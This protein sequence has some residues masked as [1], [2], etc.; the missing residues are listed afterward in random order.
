[1][2]SPKRLPGAYVPGEVENSVYKFWEK[3]RI[4]A[5]VKEWRKGRPLFN[6]LDGPPYP[7]GDMPHAGTAWNKVIKDAVLRFYRMRGYNVND[8]PGYDCH[9]L[10]IEVAVE[11]K[12]GIKVKKEIEEK[13][14]VDSFIDKCK[15]FA[16]NNINGLTKWFKRLGV[17]MDWDNPY[18]TLNDEYIEAA[19]W[20]IKK[21]NAQGLLDRDYRVVYWCPR[22]ETTLA[23]YEVEYTVLRDPSIY[24][25]F[26]LR[27]ER[28]TYI[29]VWTTTPWTLPANTFVMA[30]PEALYVKVKVGNEYYI[31][32]MTRLEK[33]MEE[34]G[35]TEYEVVERIQGKALEGKEYVNPLEELVPLQKRL[36]KYHRI[37]MAPKYV[38]LHEG[39]GF[40]HAAPGHGFEDFEVAKE[41]GVDEIISPITDDGR[42]TED[43]GK[44]AGLPAREANEEIIKDLERIGAL[45][46]RASIEHRYPICWRC[47]T[48]VLL[49]ATTQ[50]IL[51]VTRLRD[52]L[53]EEAR[54]ANWIPRWALN[55]LNAML[56]NLQ[57][58]VLSRQRYWGIP[59][60]IWICEKCGHIV[61]AGSID[62]LKRYGGS[63][64]R[65]LHK[66]WIDQVTL[67]CPKCGGVMR[68]VP[69]VVDV[70]FDSGVAFY[71]S[72]GHP[73]KSSLLLSEKRYKADFIVEGHDQT[74][75][76]FFSLL[77]A[78]VIGFNEVPYRN[79][80]VHGFM[81]DRYGRE[82]HK[83]LGNYVAISEIVEKEGADVFRFWVLQNTTWEDARFSWE[84]LEE[85]RSDLNIAWNVF[86]FAST[87][88]ELDRFD[89]GRYGLDEYWEKLRPE[90]KWLLSR[91]AK[92]VENVTKAFTEYRVHDA[93]KLL[94]DYIIGD[95][96]HWYIRLIRKRVWVEGESEDKNAAYITLYT[97]L[98]T[99]LLLAAPIIPFFTEKIYQYFVREAEPRA[100]ISVHL[101]D[102]PLVRSNWINEELE[103]EMSLV[104]DL[105][106]AVAALRMKAG[107]KLRQPLRQVIVFTDKSDVHMAL[108][109]L[110]DLALQVVN[111]KH[112]EVRT[113]GEKE[114]F[115]EYHVEPV[116]QV[117]GPEFRRKARDIVNYI[118][119]KGSEIARDIL[120]KGEHVFTIDGEEIRLTNRHVKI[121]PVYK[122]G[123]Y[124]LPRDWGTVLIDTTLSEKEISEGFARDLVRRIQ[125]MR[126]EMGL[127]IEDKITVYLDVPDDYQKYVTENYDYIAGEVRATRIKIVDRDTLEKLSDY[128]RSWDIGGVRVIIGIKREG[129]DG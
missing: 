125:Y 71:A 69:D 21:A 58:W 39:T 34:A 90:D 10:P 53:V 54:K 22:C 52:K 86:V 96:S 82:M 84:K 121:I 106:E 94:K 113:L 118:R 68:R 78:G 73:E 11:K 38:S 56:D 93:V 126:K 47:K 2:A 108:N 32:A 65:E 30:H 42:F 76:W 40:V 36:S 87:Y 55:R 17:F 7:S 79:V 120:E 101:N 112:L 44:Y 111:A 9:G 23:E 5:K 127:D 60:P 18:L 50:W 114:A 28:N 57:D 105:A 1:M 117:I 110:R 24:V 12:L 103:N 41:I 27:G 115:V 91:T 51:R 3:E 19:W 61:V 15:E 37:V 89:P 123:Y 8:R 35:I 97:A 48:P 13:I 63:V 122:T 49:R 107:I 75:G 26:P 85:A 62:D 124:A 92:L 43:A 20:L 25:K 14:G 45:F 88:M 6:F 81:L 59:L 4:Y 31:L 95:V 99:W 102:W 80:V 100:P 109:R 129:S 72:I 116:Y 104:K 83:S 74:R 46:H 119:Q 77:R 66:P 29:L 128:K 33:V 98:K 67:K 16:L 64:P 70:W